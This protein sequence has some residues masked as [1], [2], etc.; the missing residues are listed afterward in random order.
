M[1]K[2]KYN[3]N[4]KKFTDFFWGELDEFSKY[5]IGMMLIV[6]AFLTFIHM[7]SFFGF[8]FLSNILN[9]QTEWVSNKF[10]VP[11]VTDKYF[12]IDAIDIL[13]IFIILI[14]LFGWGIKSLIKLKSTGKNKK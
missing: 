3:F 9:S 8:T 10:S 6:L 14:I 5:F 7:L 4:I 2:K 13:L 1:K 11:I 12:S